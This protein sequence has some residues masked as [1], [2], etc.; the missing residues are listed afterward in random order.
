MLYCGERGL[1]TAQLSLGELKTEQLFK[2]VQNASGL[3]F[4]DFI[5]VDQFKGKVQEVN[6]IIFVQFLLS[7]AGT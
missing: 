6:P 7:S 5:T 3:L 4:R 1:L 2:T